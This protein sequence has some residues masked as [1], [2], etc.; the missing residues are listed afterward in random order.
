MNQWLKS[1]VATILVIVGLLISL[2]AQWTLLSQAADL[3]KST[4]AE[5][6]VHEQDTRRHIDPDR[7]A[8]RWQD[9]LDRLRRIE[10]ALNEK[11]R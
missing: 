7:D 3:A 4:A 10:E 1:N 2:V 5:L 6:R 9:L 11:R 8:L